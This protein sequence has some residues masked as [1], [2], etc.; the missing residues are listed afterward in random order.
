MGRHGAVGARLTTPEQRT[1]D[2][3][4]SVSRVVPHI[5]SEH[6]DESREFY[7]G[8]LGFTVVMDMGWIMTFA[9]PTHPTA[10]LTV[11]RHDASSRT[12]PGPGDRALSPS[13]VRAQV[14]ALACTLPRDSGKPLSRWSATE[15]ARAVVRCGIVRR[16]S[17]AT[18]VRPHPGLLG[19]AQSTGSSDPV[20][21]HC[22]QAPGQSPPSTEAG[23]DR[24]PG[25]RDESGA[26]PAQPLAVL[27]RP[28]WG[29]TAHPATQRRLRLG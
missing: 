26:A 21:L 27:Q 6:L 22:P 8:L 4:L 3:P 14:T 17:G 23:R 13:A 15:L 18:H 11:L 20:D 9:S 29:R 7:V 16:I 2:P 1:E 28:G 10:Q 25:V 5:Q 24:L 19:R 12:C